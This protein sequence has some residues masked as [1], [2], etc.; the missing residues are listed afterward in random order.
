MKKP[1]Q[2]DE[3]DSGGPPQPV[4]VP[5]PA[6]TEGLSLDFRGVS[7]AGRDLRNMD[8]TGVDLEGADLS[9]CNLTGAQL[10]R[11]RLKGANLSKARLDQA[12]LSG[13]DLTDA[14]LEEAS[15]EGVGLGMAILHRARLFQCRLAGAT[16]SKADLSGADLRCADLRGARF[17][18]TNLTGT[19]FTSADLREASLSQSTVTGASFRNALIQDARLRALK[20]FQRADWIGVDIHNINFA[21]AYRLRRHV[22]D[23]N[24]LKEFRES[25]R[26]ARLLYA[27]WWATSDCGR[28][29]FRWGLWI[30][31]LTLFFAWLYSLVGVD[32]GPHPTALSPLYF[33][34][35]TFTTLGFGDVVPATPAAQLVAM[36]EVLFGYIMLGGLLSIFSNI[37]ARRGD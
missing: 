17:R 21:G 4:S 11:A 34:V 1:L 15:A 8:F 10:F 36:T 37:I 25:S 28:S 22:I 6:E 18:E 16:F 26:V 9:G 29:I 2:S 20:G 23:E 31:A 32:Y 3:G 24:Y 30:A 5:L 12:E 14:H 33:S 13:A 35:V 27:V 7:L 19:D